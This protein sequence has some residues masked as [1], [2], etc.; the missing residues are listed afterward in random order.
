MVVRQHGC[1]FSGQRSGEGR[2]DWLLL[3]GCLVRWKNHERND[4]PSQDS[5]C[6]I[7]RRGLCDRYDQ[8]PFARDLL[9]QAV[10]RASEPP[11][12]VD[13]E[14][15]RAAEEAHARG[16]SKPFSKQ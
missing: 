3:S 13:W 9:A 16:E 12:P 2:R 11:R 5:D 4:D 10:A 1:I 8:G 7:N 6:W 15:V 14:R